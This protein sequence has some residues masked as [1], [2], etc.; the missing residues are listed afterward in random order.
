[1]NYEL[2]FYISLVFTVFSVSVTC[3]SFWL[4]WRQR[5]KHSE[6]QLQKEEKE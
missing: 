5:Q 4:Q 3:F 6:K 1:M 2:A